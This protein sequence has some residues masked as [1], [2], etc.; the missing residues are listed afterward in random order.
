[1]VVNAS[2]RVVA[3]GLRYGTAHTQEPR[4]REDRFVPTMVRF[5]DPAALSVGEQLATDKMPRLGRS[6]KCA[7]WGNV[8]WERSRSVGVSCARVPNRPAR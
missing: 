6:A 4:Q 3:V 2:A 5:P 1:M 7:R 8:L